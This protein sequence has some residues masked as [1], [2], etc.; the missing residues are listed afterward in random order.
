MHPAQPDP[1]PDRRASTKSRCAYREPGPS[2][3]QGLDFRFLD[4]WFERISLEGPFSTESEPRLGIS[5]GDHSGYGL[6]S[7]GNHQILAGA[8]DLIEQLE[9]LGLEFGRSNH[10]VTSLNDRSFDARMSF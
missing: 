3:F 2:S 6:S 7:F 9:A 1:I 5:L 10:H 8:L 4:A